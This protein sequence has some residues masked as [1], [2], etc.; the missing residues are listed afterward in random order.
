TSAVTPPPPTVEIVKP[1]C[2]SPAPLLGQ[3]DP[4]VPRYIAVYRDGVDPGAETDRLATKFGFQP[5]FVYTHALAGFSAELSPPVVAS[6]RCE[7]RVDYVEFDQ[8][9]TIDG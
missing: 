6:V 2:L 5:R 7:A 9:I 4:A 1:P 3:F 8:R